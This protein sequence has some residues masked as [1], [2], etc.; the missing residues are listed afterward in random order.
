VR[1]S[2]PL[3]LVRKLDRDG[4]LELDLDDEDRGRS[5]RLARR[6]RSL[7]DI[8]RAGLGVLLEVEERSGER[9]LVWLS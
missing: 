6:L 9:V 8:E 2:L 4:R 5:R 7:K 3:W 1:I